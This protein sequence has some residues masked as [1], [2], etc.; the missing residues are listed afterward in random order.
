MPRFYQ[1]SPWYSTFPLGHYSFGNRTQMPSQQLLQHIHQVGHIFR[2]IFRHLHP[3]LLN[4]TWV[5][6]LHGLRN[7]LVLEWG[8]FEEARRRL[9]KYQPQELRGPAKVVSSE[10]YHSE[11]HFHLQIPQRGECSSHIR[12]T[13]PVAVHKK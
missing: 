7:L 2:R 10:A 1:S 6:E 4:Q 13:Q 12:L 5:P 8:T 3:I 11:S 9:I